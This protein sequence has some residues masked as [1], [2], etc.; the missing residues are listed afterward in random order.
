MALVLTATCLLALTPSVAFAHPTRMPRELPLPGWLLGWAAAL[1]LIISFVAL[2]AWRPQHVEPDRWHPLPRR[3]S[4]V[5]VNP[6]TKGATGAI[7]ALLLGVVAWSGLWGSQSLDR[8]FSVTFVFVTTWLG[9]VV[10]SVLFGDVF[11]ALNPW[12]AI[13]HA[14]AV[15]LRR[16]S[17]PVLRY[18]DRLGCWPAVAGL[19]GFIWLELV[20]GQLNFTMGGGV[21][22]HAT[23]VATLVYSGWTFL[24]MALF[25]IDRWLSVGEVFSVYFRMFAS[26]SPLQI[27]DGRLGVRPPFAGAAQWADKPGCI[28]LVLVAIGGSAFDGAQE[29]V[30]LEPIGDVLGSLSAAGL[31]GVASLRLAT[32]FFFAA[33]VATIATV[34]W[35]G[36]RG[37]RTAR[38]GLS[39]RELGRAIVHSFIPIALG[40]LIAHYFSLLIYSGQAQFTYLMS[41]PLANG[42]NYFGTADNLVHYTLISDAAVWYTQ[43]AAL[44][45]GHAVALVLG[46]DRA[47]LVYGDSREVARS[48]YW[49]LTLMVVFTIFGLYLLSQ[50]NQ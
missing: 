48:Q 39:T 31:A 14:A 6:L 1:V 2:S 33:T 24:G 4:E 40:Y 20:Y 34:F 8:N 32:T 49:M 5:I 11:R 45:L 10:T 19:A 50:G 37:M 21:T 26:L 46:H 27:R 17:G 35:L 36:V 13:A 28:A 44:V 12:R 15:T 38:A 43:T 30:L 9:M 25:G 18:P 23:A 16:R 7:G 3:V 29:S 47:M 42:S 41:D 22:P